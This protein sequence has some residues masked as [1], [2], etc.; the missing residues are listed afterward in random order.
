M[1]KNESN[2]SAPSKTLV[3]AAFTSVYLIWGSTYTG[4]L[5]AIKTIPPFCMAGI[6]FFASGIILIIYCLIKGEKIPDKNSVFKNSLVGILMLFFG[7]TSLIWVEQF[8]P[9]GLCAITVAIVPLWFVFLDKKNYK[10][11]FSDKF[12]LIGLLV[13]FAGII[14]L[15]SGKSSVDL[16]HNTA[17]L[18]A[19]IVLVTSGVLWAIGSLYSKYANAAGSTFMKGGIQMMAA[20]LCGFISAFIAGEQHHFYLHKISTESWEALIY[21]VFMGSIVGYIAYIWL[22]SV[23]P[24]SIVGTYAYVNPVVAVFLGWFVAGETISFIQL[25]ALII[26]LSGVLLVNFSK[27]KK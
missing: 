1:Q 27:Y 15:F 8:L 16:Q 6:R 10:Q 5:L 17:Q 4:I 9:S 12:I 2:S 11:N 25:I 23:R 13:G 14:L 24:P 20:G 21:L 7:T 18:I 22:L 19:F 3:M 26:I